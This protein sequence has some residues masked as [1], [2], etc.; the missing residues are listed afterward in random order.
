M[1]CS[2]MVRPCAEGKCRDEHYLPPDSHQTCISCTV[3]DIGHGDDFTFDFLLF[4]AELPADY[5]KYWF[6]Y[7]HPLCSMFHHTKRLL[8]S[9]GQQ[10]GIEN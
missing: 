6:S 1:S 8:S 2:D 10:N 3:A 4:H 9:L 7:C 5:E